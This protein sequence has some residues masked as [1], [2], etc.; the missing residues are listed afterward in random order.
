MNFI[1][2][3]NNSISAR[4]FQIEILPTRWLEYKLRF[5]L[6]YVFLYSNYKL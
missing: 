1:D 5:V 2:A 3:M 4:S 6:K